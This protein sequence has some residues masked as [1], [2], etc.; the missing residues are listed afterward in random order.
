MATAGGGAPQPVLSIIT[1]SFNSA[2]FLPETLE[3]VAS[4]ETRHE[5]IVIDGGST[6]G[7]IELLQAR[8]DPSLVWLSEPDR[9]Q[10]HAVN[11]GLQRARGEV[12]AWLNS[13]D[14]YV[15]EHVD[16]AVRLLLQS[17]EI[18]AV[19]GFM[20]IVDEHGRVL[21]RYRSPA[22]SWRR[23]VYLGDYLPTPT[24]IFRR[25]LLVRAA[26]LDE[27]YLDAADCDFVLRLLRGA[28]VRRVRRPL[29][30]FRYHRASKTASNLDLQQREALEIRLRYA[31]NRVERSLIRAVS[32]VKRLRQSVSPFLP[33]PPLDG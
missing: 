33:H 25:S 30:R 14:Q 8:R 7:T 9:G 4:L 26:R 29:V 15:G 13:D 31:R 27:S 16:A 19:F 1:P 20:E 17:R 23:Y 12:L 6:D 21:K 5:H 18:D 3:S 28:K 32:R 2:R 22:F 24:V 11:K 10:S